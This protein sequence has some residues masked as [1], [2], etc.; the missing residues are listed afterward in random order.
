MDMFQATEATEWVERRY[1]EALAEPVFGRQ[2]V[3]PSPESVSDTQGQ[4]GRYTAL[5]TAVTL[6]VVLLAVVAG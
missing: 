4:P 1:K 5:I 3:R 2:P 6:L